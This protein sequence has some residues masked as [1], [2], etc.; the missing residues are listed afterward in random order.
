MRRAAWLAV[1]LA[2]A[3]GLVCAETGQLSKRT[4]WIVPYDYRETLRVSP[5]DVIEVWTK[6]L[7]VIP[8]NLEARFRASREGRGVELV[9]E[10]LPHREGTMERL[11]LFKAFDPGPAVLKVEM[12]NREGEVQ[13]T[14][15]Y[16]VEV[17]PQPKPEV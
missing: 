6:P 5:G 1:G 8:E 4:V 17:S 11:Y 7:A 10:V 15:T 16:P 2:M 13:Q 9:G 14:W 12:L 3:A